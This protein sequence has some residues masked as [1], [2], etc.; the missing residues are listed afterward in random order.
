MYRSSA[1][2]SLEDVPSNPHGGVR[3][4]DSSKGVPTD[5]KERARRNVGTTQEG[6]LVI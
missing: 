5:R 6:L 2:E 4:E 1:D 3:G